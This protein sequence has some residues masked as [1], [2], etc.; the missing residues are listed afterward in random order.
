[1]QRRW[2][3]EVLVGASIIV[4]IVIVIYGYI[5]LRDLP[6]RQQGFEIDI[7]FKDVTGLQ[8]GDA[9]TV[10]GMKVGRV[11]KMEL[12]DD[13]VT[14]RAWLN[15]KIPYPRDSRAAIRS[16]GMIGEKYI[17]LMLGTAP[18]GLGADDTIAGDYISDLADAGGG[19]NELMGQASDLLRKLNSAMDTVIQRQSPGELS[20]TL[21]NV[22]Q[23]SES[24]ARRLDKNL[25]HLQR[26][27]ESLDT[28]STDFK[29]VWHVRRERIDSTMTHVA[30]TA[31]LMP[32]AISQLDSMLTSTR[33][34]LAS[35]EEQEGS[36]GKAIKSDE[37]Y[38]RANRLMLQL[39]EILADVKQYP[40]KYF[41]V[42][43]F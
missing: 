36:V 21:K 22:N 34:L 2:S 30:E 33:R 27:L 40:Q 32:H 14:V 18:V 13:H 37:L 19:V 15:G 41:Q 17:D 12:A 9:V 6:V 5:F 24:L 42:K 20:S 4:A 43:V 16:I 11:Q 23:I 29:D 35:L 25:L 7:M 10:S 28:L 26:T 3:H 1:M 31:R 8:V 38:D 39:E